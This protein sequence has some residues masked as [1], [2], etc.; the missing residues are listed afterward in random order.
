MRQACVQQK[1]SHRHLCKA[2]DFQL[3]KYYC[4]ILTDI[5]EE[6]IAIWKGFS[7]YM[8]VINCIFWVNNIYSDMSPLSPVLILMASWRS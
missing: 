5:I 3:T 6:Q 7:A 1:L 8:P 4:P 2:F